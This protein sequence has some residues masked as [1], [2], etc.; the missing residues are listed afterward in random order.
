MSAAATAV[1][2]CCAP[3]SERGPIIFHHEFAISMSLH[4]TLA[5]QKLDMLPLCLPASLA[6]SQVQPLIKTSVS[7]SWSKGA[8]P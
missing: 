1:A 4:A 8:S 2:P 6:F 5:L 3:F 7:L